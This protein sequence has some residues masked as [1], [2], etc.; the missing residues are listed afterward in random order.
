[1]QA[2]DAYVCIDRNMKEVTPRFTLQADALAAGE[3][4]LLLVEDDSFSLV[5]VRAG[6]PAGATP[7]PGSIWWGYSWDQGYVY[8]PSWPVVPDSYW[9]S[10]WQWPWG[11]NRFRYIKLG[12]LRFFN[13]SVTYVAL[14]VPDGLKRGDTDLP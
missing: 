9:N 7:D 6:V 1:M 3:A 14:D 13:G 10:W 4:Q 11:V 5:L 2:G 12:Q 8:Q